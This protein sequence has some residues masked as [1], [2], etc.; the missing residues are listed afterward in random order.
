MIRSR[1]LIGS[2]CLI[3]FFLSA[4]NSNNYQAVQDQLKQGWNTWSTY[5]MGQHVLLPSGIT[6]NLGLH[7]SSKNS[8][9]FV[10]RFFV[11]KKANGFKKPIVKPGYHSYSGD[12]T[13]MEIT[14]KKIRLRIES[15]AYGAD[16]Y[17]LVTPIE[18][19][20]E[21]KGTLLVEGGILWK[22]PGSVSASASALTFNTPDGETSFKATSTPSQHPF[23]NTISPFLAIDLAG[24]LGISNAT[25]ALNEVQQKVAEKRKAYENYLKQFGALSEAYA[26]MAAGLGWNTIYDPINDRV[27]STV[28][29]Q[30]NISRG[31]YVF[32]GWDNFFMAHMIGLDAPELA[33]AN[34]VEA[35]RE[36][37]AEGFI[38]N[39]SQGNGRKAWDRSQPPVGGL[40]CWA[41]YEKYQHKWFLE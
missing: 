24:P 30:W 19:D 15:A 8:D 5:S 18:L 10:N 39:V 12:Y 13:S 7:K 22:R 11:D 41:I 6:L 38:S 36:A 31:G 3:S 25:E 35:L 26:G 20:E 37:A 16:L 4:Q 1:L 2:F 17:L 28:D 33:M 40:A 23:F 27:F 21:Y 29:R 34:A 9:R 32:F 14:Y